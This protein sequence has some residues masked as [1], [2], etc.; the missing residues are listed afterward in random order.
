MIRA[1]CKGAIKYLRRAM[2]NNVQ[3][4]TWEKF[5][6]KHSEKVKLHTETHTEMTFISTKAKWFAIHIYFIF[7]VSLKTLK[8]TK[9][10]QLN[11]DVMN[12]TK[13]LAFKR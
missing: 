12:I 5:E 9:R 13:P 4:F 1:A 6:N 2:F 10:C 3:Y 11:F 8:R 7:D